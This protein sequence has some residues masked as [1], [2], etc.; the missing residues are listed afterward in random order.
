MLKEEVRP[1]VREMLETILNT[2]RAVLQDTREHIPMFLIG[3]GDEILGQVMAPFRNAEEKKLVAEGVRKICT[4]FEADFVI[5]VAESYAY[6]GP[7][8]E[9]KIEQY[10]SIS[11]I[12]GCKEI[13][14]IMY[15]SDSYEVSVISEISK[16]EHFVSLTNT[17]WVVGDSKRGGMFSNLIPRKNWH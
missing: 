16:T 17:E 7:D 10:G 15:E 11:K 6:S 3:K 13:L 5:F 14:M 4:E 1:K 12:P 8:T 9:S 2:S